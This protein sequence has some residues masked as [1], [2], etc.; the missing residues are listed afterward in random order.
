MILRQYFVALSIFSIFSCKSGVHKDDKQMN[1]DTTL[2]I[3]TYGLPD[4]EQQAAMNAVAKKYGFHYFQVAGCVISK[5]LVDSADKENNRV[6][7]ILR[8]KFGKDW[9][10]IFETEVA[11]M[12]RLQA[13]AEELVKDE[14]YIID[15]E[16][17]LD[18]DGNRLYYLI[19]PAEEQNL[20]TVKVYGMGL[21]N[22]ESQ[23]VLYY[24]LLVD[25]KNKRVTIKSSMLEPF[26]N[27][28]YKS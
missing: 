4:D 22:R 23:P 2:K 6:Y 26:Y 17:E 14:N 13:N 9:Q 3:L 27:Y 21:W 20:F 5:N 28:N 24:N 10:S 7:E 25:L 11:T 15:K 8:Q 16:K 18:K 19:D 1:V 12:I